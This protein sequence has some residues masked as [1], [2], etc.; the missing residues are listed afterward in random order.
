MNSVRHS[1]NNLYVIFFDEYFGLNTIVKKAV[2]LNTDVISEEEVTNLIQIGIVENDIRVAVMFEQQYNNLLDCKV[3]KST[4]VP[5]NN[6][7]DF[8]EDLLM[9]QRE[10]M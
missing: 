10:Q 5:Y 4:V 1:T 3:D 9:E 7:E 6:D 2:L 8:L